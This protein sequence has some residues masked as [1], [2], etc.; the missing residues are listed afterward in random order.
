[1]FSPVGMVDV[2]HIA[3]LANAE[4]AFY[5]RTL[6]LKSRINVYYHETARHRPPTADGLPL[7]QADGSGGTIAY[8]QNYLG[9]LWVSFH[10]FW[11][12]SVH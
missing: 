4:K 1:M 11:N 9:V 5:P 12:P 8:S 6:R 10:Y 3:T 2:C 7:C